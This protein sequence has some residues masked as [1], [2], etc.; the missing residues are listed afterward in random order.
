MHPLRQQLNASF[1][2]TP[3]IQASER[4]Q[5]TYR[6][7]SYFSFHVFRTAFPLFPPLIRLSY[8]ILHSY[9][10]TFFFSLFSSSSSGRCWSNI[11]FSAQ[12]SYRSNYRLCSLLFCNQCF[13]RLTSPQLPFL[14]AFSVGSLLFSCAHTGCLSST[15]QCFVCSFHF[16]PQNRRFPVKAGTRAKW[17][18]WAVSRRRRIDQDRKEATK[19]FGSGDGNWNGVDAQVV[20][21]NLFPFI[22]KFLKPLFPRNRR[23]IA[24]LEP[25]L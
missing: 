20:M 25:S 5:T 4:R 6:S 7:T 22:V 2:T 14:F 3:T 11:G 16:R 13:G 12:F 10:L 18:Q 24:A 21:V 9:F 23:I 19:R 8:L 1:C 15:R 17:R